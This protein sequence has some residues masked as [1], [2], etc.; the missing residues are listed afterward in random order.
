MSAQQTTSFSH[1]TGVIEQLCANEDLPR[2]ISEPCSGGG[3]IARARRRH[4]IGVVESD[5]NPRN[6]QPQADF[7]KTRELAPFARNCYAP[8]RSR[9]RSARRRAQMNV[10]VRGERPSSAKLF[11]QFL[12]ERIEWDLQITAAIVFWRWQTTAS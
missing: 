1:L 8:L 11:R 5:L 10:F 7:L 6:S 12:R 4:G 2:R 3:A 9:R